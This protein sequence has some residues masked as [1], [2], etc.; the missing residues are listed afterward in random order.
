MSF[1]N[2]WILS[3][4]WVCKILFKNLYNLLKKKIKILKELRESIVYVFILQY[5]NKSID[6]VIKK[7][8]ALLG[9]KNTN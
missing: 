8:Y 6:S 4:L 5:E 3:N 1:Y 2:I 9:L 7:Y